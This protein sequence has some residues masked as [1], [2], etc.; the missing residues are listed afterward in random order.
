MA[1]SSLDIIWSELQGRIC[2]YLGWPRG[3]PYNDPPGLTSIQQ[4]ELDGIT[5]SGLRSFYYPASEIAFNWSFLMPTASL[6]L[7]SGASTL[8]LPNDFGSPEGQVTVQPSGSQAQPW[9]VAWLNE[10]QVR[11][12]YSTFPTMTGPPM[13]VSLQAIK[14]T[15]SN[16]GQQWQLYFFPLSDQAYTVQLA[17]SVCP[18]YLSTPFP[19]AYGGA[20]HAETILESCLAIAEQRLDDTA[21]VHAALFQS[22][23]QASMA[24]DRKNKPQN[25]G[26]N[27][28]NS[29]LPAWNRGQQHWW[30]GAI[31]YNGSPFSS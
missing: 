1:Q 24:L 22:R 6:A 20:Q 13:Y 11:E 17:Y 2:T 8:A 31:T 5:A 28:D 10:A 26:Y 3:A 21:T 14:G 18:D 15:S 9:D 4:F 16:L 19:Y 27:R 25:L 23:L 7:A 30:A 29:D 12:K